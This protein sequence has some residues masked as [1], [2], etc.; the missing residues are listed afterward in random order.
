V[1]PSTAVAA[2]GCTT[3]SPFARIS[4]APTVTVTEARAGIPTTVPADSS[5]GAASALPG[6]G[7]PAPGIISK[8][9]RPTDFVRDTECHPRTKDLNAGHRG[10]SLVKKAGRNSPPAPNGQ[11]VAPKRFIVASCALRTL[12][13]DEGQYGEPED[14]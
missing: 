6:I 8:S 12:R 10:T 1:V 4:S 3:T 2:S 5:G 14:C 13:G 11:C 7:T 9:M